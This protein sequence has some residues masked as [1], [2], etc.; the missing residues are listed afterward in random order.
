VEQRLARGCV[1]THAAP[2]QAC[3]THSTCCLVNARLVACD[4][5]V[6]IEQTLTPTIR[7]RLTER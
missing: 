7:A 6:T 2:S 5:G 4:A 3:L 1:L